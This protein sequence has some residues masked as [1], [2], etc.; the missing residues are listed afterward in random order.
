MLTVACDGSSRLHFLPICCRQ[1][2]GLQQQQ[3]LTQDKHPRLFRV[4][5]RSGTTLIRDYLQVSVRGID[6]ELKLCELSSDH[7]HRLAEVPRRGLKR[8]HDVGLHVT[9]IRFLTTPRY[10][11]FV[12]W[13]AWCNCPPTASNR[14]DGAP[15]T[16]M[17]TTL[18]LLYLDV[19][20]FVLCGRPWNPGTRQTLLQ[21]GTVE[22]VILSICSWLKTSC[23]V[24]MTNQQQPIRRVSHITQSTLECAQQAE[25]PAATPNSHACLWFH[26]CTKT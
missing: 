18:G 8:R 16:R 25:S 26:H 1:A 5:D 7:H 15:Q 24:D 11:W 6:C 12:D 20:S 19:R 3:H 14:T 10:C 4:A 21:L 23:F 22:H 9:S 13:Q 17:P 2:R